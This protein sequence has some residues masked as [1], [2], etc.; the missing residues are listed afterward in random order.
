[1][2]MS[3]P[4]IKLE[5]KKQLEPNIVS[6]DDIDWDC[7]QNDEFIRETLL[8][9][10]PKEPEPFGENW[11][12]HRRWVG[13]GRRHKNLFSR[14]Y[15][16]VEN[17]YEKKISASI[18]MI[19]AS[20]SALSYLCREAYENGFY[21]YYNTEIN[22][23]WCDVD[24]CESAV[25][26]ALSNIAAHNKSFELGFGTT[27]GFWL[28]M[29]YMMNNMFKSQEMLTDD[30]PFY[31]RWLESN[32]IDEI[33]DAIRNSDVNYGGKDWFKIRDMCIALR[34]A[35]M[36]RSANDIEQY[37]SFDEMRKAKQER[38][39]ASIERVGLI[40]SARKE[41]DEE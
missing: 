13:V 17:Y 31:Y 22:G 37:E 1:M 29:Y 38:I 16:K 14:R 11:H 23:R 32:P 24:A 9:F 26:G 3:E 18:N 34:A 28:C 6:K 12:R 20:V 40:F 36:R 4:V 27:Y 15:D 30:R 10:A 33:D 41:S 35:G 8:R 19:Y 39:R 5:D 2:T 7:L 25:V 21:A